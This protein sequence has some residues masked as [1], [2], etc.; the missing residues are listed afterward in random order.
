[1]KINTKVVFEWNPKSKQY[2]EIY[3]D[4]YEHDGEVAECQLWPWKGRQQQSV[5]SPT[6]GVGYDYP[7]PQSNA[8]DEILSIISLYHE[9]IIKNRT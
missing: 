9:K 7:N 1:M 5:P 8:A 6:V 3:C 4:S 2:E